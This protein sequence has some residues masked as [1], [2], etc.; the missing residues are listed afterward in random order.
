MPNEVNPYASPQSPEGPATLPRGAKVFATCPKCQNVYAT[1][2][3]YTL[4]GG[5]LGP[6][7]FTHVRCCQCRTAYN[8]KTGRSNLTNIVLYMT[9]PAMVGFVFVLAIVVA[10]VLKR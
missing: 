7:M 6:W 4:W 10:A 1:R 3:G 8:G 2:I 9:V 5:A